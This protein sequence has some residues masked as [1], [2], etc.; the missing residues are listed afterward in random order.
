MLCLPSAA[1]NLSQIKSE[2]PGEV[3]IRFSNFAARSHVV[4]GDM[5]VSIVSPPEL[6]VELLSKCLC[7]SQRTHFK[8]H[9]IKPKTCSCERG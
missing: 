4:P 7:I 1:I 8:E 9:V 6:S 5:P 2:M 3:K